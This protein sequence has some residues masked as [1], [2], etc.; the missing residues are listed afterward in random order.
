M[1]LPHQ[2]LYCPSEARLG[3]LGREVAGGFCVDAQNIKLLV[4]C[5]LQR[6]KPFAGDRREG[7]NLERV[8]VEF[9]QD[10]QPVSGPQGYPPD[11]RLSTRFL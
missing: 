10:I 5:S 7:I 6:F 8:T 1:M 9:T 11:S 3:H 2:A 4:N